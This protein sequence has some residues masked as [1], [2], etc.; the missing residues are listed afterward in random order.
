MNCLSAV[1]LDVLVIEGVV[2]VPVEG[3]KLVD[4]NAL[5]SKRLC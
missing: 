2:I 3:S 4:E 1:V 5:L